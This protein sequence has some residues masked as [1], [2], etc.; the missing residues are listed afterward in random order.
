MSSAAAPMAGTLSKAWS[1]FRA[2]ATRF[3]LTEGEPLGLSIE[4][5][6]AAAS[7]RL[8]DNLVLRAAHHFAKRFPG[9][10][11]GAFHLVKRLPVAAGLGGGS[12]D[13]AAALRLLARANARCDRRRA[14]LRG[15][16]RRPGPM[17]RSASSAAR[18]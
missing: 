2:A 9:A 18:G 3:T 8:E 11:L 13:A 5:P 15:R 14:P 7:G 17:C 6:A 16:A 1:P 4:G 12:S 10:K